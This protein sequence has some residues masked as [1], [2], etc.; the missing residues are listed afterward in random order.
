MPLFV[1][2]LVFKPVGAAGALGRVVALTDAAAES[3]P[4]LL[5]ST[6]KSYSVLA[7]KPVKL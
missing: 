2:P 5:A 6:S 4:A 3:P 1:I 7:V